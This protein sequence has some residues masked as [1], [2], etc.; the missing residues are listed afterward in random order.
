[1]IIKW[2]KQRKNIE[3]KHLKLK[4]KHFGDSHGNGKGDD[5]KEERPARENYVKKK[6]VQNY[7]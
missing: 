3:K 4:L 6:C 5:A 7:Q 1:M 2:L